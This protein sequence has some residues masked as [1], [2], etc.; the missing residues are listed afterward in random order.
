MSQFSFGPIQCLISACVCFNQNINISNIASILQAL[1]TA[2]FLSDL[3]VCVMCLV[4]V[5]MEK[6]PTHTTAAVSYKSKL[7]SCTLWEFSVQAINVS[8]SGINDN[9][10]D[11]ITGPH[12]HWYLWRKTIC[13]NKHESGKNLITL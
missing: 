1:F 13:L 4:E 6:K 3:T 2:R 11:P 5:K 12:S 8:Y 10:S 7:S 9:A